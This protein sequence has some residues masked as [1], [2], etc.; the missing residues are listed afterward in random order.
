MK[1]STYIFHEQPGT[2]IQYGNTNAACCFANSDVALNGPFKKLAEWATKPI[3]KKTADKSGLSHEQ[4]EQFINRANVVFD[5]LYQKFEDDAYS[6][7]KIAAAFATG[8]ATGGPLRAFSSAAGAAAS[9]FQNNLNK[10]AE[11]ISETISPPENAPPET[12]E[13]QKKLL[14][15]GGGVL[16]VGSLLLFMD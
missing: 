15:I 1:S 9:E 5:P 12:K 10:F 2:R 4:K 6:T 13:N 3:V 14:L 11:R 16:I 8:M 7:P